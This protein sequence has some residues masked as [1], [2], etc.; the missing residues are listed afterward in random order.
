MHE[1]VKQPNICI[2]KVTGEDEKNKTG[3]LFKEIMAENFL[4]LM[5][6]IRPLIQDVF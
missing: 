6:E 2:V 3:A 4:K 1:T 5:K